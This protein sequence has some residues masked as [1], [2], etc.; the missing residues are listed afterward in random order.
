M[1]AQWT[2]DQIR[3]LLE[4]LC[5]SDDGNPDL[6]KESLQFFLNETSWDFLEKLDDIGT[7]CDWQCTDDWNEI[8]P[9]KDKS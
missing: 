8:R 7:K 1:S 4:C 6:I 5:I 9:I 3:L 2:D